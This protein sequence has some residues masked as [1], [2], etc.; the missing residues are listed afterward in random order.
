MGSGDSVQ[1]RN[2]ESVIESISPTA[3]AGVRISIVGADTFVRLEAMGHRVEVPGYEDEP[4]L[5]INTKGVVEINDSSQTTL[6]NSDRYGNS[7]L[8]T[9]V[10]SDIPRWRTIATD[11]IAMWHDHRSH[12]MS[13]LRPAPIDEKGTV[14]TWKIP[15]VVD[16]GPL[17]VNGS[18]YIR[19]EASMGWWLVGLGALLFA[20][21]L[22]ASN[23][24]G[25]FIFVTAVSLFA[26]AVGAQEFLGLPLNAQITPV[27]LLF[28]GGATVL[29][30]LALVANRIKTV[31]QFS[32][33]LLA[34]AGAAL[35]INAW[36]CIDQ[37]RAAYVPG[38]SSPWTARVAV[39]AMLGAGVVAV[40]HSISRVIKTN[41]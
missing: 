33:P 16:G 13:P 24:A 27:M 36:L 20:I 38:L 9:F 31:T 29:S 23:S 34:G 41:A 19:D 17:S 12:W 39:T 2:T 5:R 7:D 10:K 26:V 14:L 37:V 32:Y 22:L 35:V 21:V 4:Y 11:G 15:M 1:P 28:A 30:A 40:F 8:S 6:L 25:L 3:P 18:L